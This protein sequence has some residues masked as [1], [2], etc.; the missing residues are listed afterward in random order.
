[1]YKDG[2]Q[3]KSSLYD[4]K[5]KEPRRFRIKVSRAPEPNSIFWENLEVSRC[6]RFLRKLLSV[7]IAVLCI[8]L[9]ITSIAWGRSARDAASSKNA[10]NLR[11]CP[12]AANL[13]DDGSVAH[14]ASIYFGSYK[15]GA[16]DVERAPFLDNKKT[17]DSGAA[18]LDGLAGGGTM[19]YDEMCNPSSVRAEDGQNAKAYKAATRNTKVIYYFQFTNW[20]RPSWLYPVWVCPDSA[21]VCWPDIHPQTHEESFAS[22][23]MTDADGNGVVDN[24]L[25]RWRPQDVIKTCPLSTNYT[26][27]VDFNQQATCLHPTPNEIA[28]SGAACSNQTHAVLR[29]SALPMYPLDRGTFVENP[30]QEVAAKYVNFIPSSP[31]WKR[32]HCRA[33]SDLA[34][35]G[36]HLS[37][38]DKKYCCKER[39]L[40][41]MAQARSASITTFNGKKISDQVLD[42]LTDFGPVDRSAEGG[43]KRVLGPVDA[44][45]APLFPK[46]QA[47]DA[48]GNW[49]APYSDIPS[50]EQTNALREAWAAFARGTCSHPCT[51]INSTNMI[52]PTLSCVS[53]DSENSQASC[54]MYTANT[55]PGCYCNAQARQKAAEGNNWLMTYGTLLRDPVCWQ[56]Y[57]NMYQGDL[58]NVLSLGMVVIINVVLTLVVK[59]LAKLERPSHW[60]VVR[61]P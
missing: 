9:S 20:K 21:A 40:F 25:C 7:A 46:R 27:T 48:S 34:S 61:F 4:H 16:G 31:S 11:L 6:N 28:T 54:E 45:G 30:L 47:Q 55:V 3:I 22:P 35:G 1:M 15:R 13:T 57:L 33:C 38:S 19:S 23:L 5:R 60:L 36:A 51:Y 49:K 59:S 8:F 56:F 58:L 2:D 29:W 10:P 17:G 53:Q 24:G 32:V 18:R 39:D 41:A 50:A 42:T 26:A 37:P 44:N 14:L 52:C 43:P 12:A